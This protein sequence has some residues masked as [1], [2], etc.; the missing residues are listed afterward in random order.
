MA[1]RQWFA[2]VLLLPVVAACGSSAGHRATPAAKVVRPGTTG[3]VNLDNRPFRLHVPAGY[4]RATPAPLVVLL[5]GYSVDSHSTDGYFKIGTESDRRGFLY[6]LPEGTFD[7]RGNRFWNASDACCD[8]SGKGIDDS[9]Y[10]SRLIDTVKASYSVD[11]RRV[12][13]IGHSNGGFMAYRMACDHAGQVTAIVSVAGAMPDDPSRCKP[14]RPVSVLEV[15]G[16]ADKGVAFGGGVSAGHRYPSVDASIADWRTL[17]GCGGP[18][19]AVKTPIDLDAELPGAETAV[20]AWTGCRNSTQVALWAVKG[21][22]HGPP[23]N[24]A[25]AP[26]VVDFF[27]RQVSPA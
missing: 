16:T 24:G 8:F 2:A 19:D 27:Y 4:D 21:G 13:V 18:D 17:D 3:S 14:E 10:L 15:H 9:G 22:P 26:S 6:A 20:S 7:G 23:F 12:Y 5:H 11:A 25:F 1:V